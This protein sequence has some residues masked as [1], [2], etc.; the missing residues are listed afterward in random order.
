MSAAIEVSH[1]N[2]PFTG[3][4]KS[5]TNSECPIE[6]SIPGWR[7]EIEPFRESSKF[8]FNLWKSA[9]SPYKGTVFEIKNRTKNKFHYAIRRG[10]VKIFELKTFELLFNYNSKFFNT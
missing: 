6:K 2:I 4:H 9:G 8:W 10:L 5:D 1:S 3:S 7:E